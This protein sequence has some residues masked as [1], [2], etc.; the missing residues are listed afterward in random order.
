MDLFIKD[1]G[2]K[3]ELEQEEEFAYFLTDFIMTDSGLME[4]RVFWEDS[5]IRIVLCTKD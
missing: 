1:N 2:A 3:M 5:F 4:S